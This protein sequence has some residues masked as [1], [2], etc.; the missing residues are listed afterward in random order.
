MRQDQKQ[1]ALQRIEK[2]SEEDALD[3][4]FENYPV[5]GKD[6]LLGIE[7]LCSLQFKK[8]NR[9]SG[10]GYYSSLRAFGFEKPYRL[11]LNYV[12]MSQFL[13]LMSE[14]A[15]RDEYSKRM[16]GYFLPALVKNSKLNT[17]QQILWDS[18]VKR[19]T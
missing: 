13:R 3:W 8:K 12:G 7:I 14:F 10:A 5:D 16:V 18:I 17:E 9:L 4:L 11:I 1:S 6:S 15:D 19:T 2:L